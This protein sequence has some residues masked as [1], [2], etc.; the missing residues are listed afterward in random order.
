MITPILEKW[1]LTGHAKNKIHH[2][3]YG[4]FSQIQI[5][6]DSFIVI[7][8]IY[9][10]GWLNQKLENIYDMSWKQF[11][12]FTE[13]ALKIQSDK[14]SPMYYQMRNEVNFQYFWN[15]DPTS[16]L[17]LMNAPINDAQFDDYILLTPKKPVIF[18]TFITAYD[19]LNFT[20]Y[21]NSLLPAAATFAPVNNKANEKPIPDGVAGSNVLL[22]CTL[23]GTNGTTT[24]INPPS[25]LTSKPPIATVPTDNTQNYH[26]SLD[27]DNAVD[28][29]SF[30]H[31]PV[32]GLRLKYTD[33]VTNPLISIEYCII[34]KNIA[35][36]LSTL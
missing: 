20:I 22:N 16:V 4:M 6:D 11:F 15:G 17:K 30:L 32:S 9:W 12:Q 25:V 27:K 34:Q 5:P 2:I 26:Q 31:N 8:K 1:L 33:Q 23:L 14:E 19:Y 13:Y 24:T 29:G 10:N 3:G 7:H 35:G 36:K 18:D 21:R 28:H